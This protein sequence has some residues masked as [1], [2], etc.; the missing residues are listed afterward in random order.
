MIKKNGHNVKNNKFDTQIHTVY[1]G[2]QTTLSQEELQEIWAKRAYALAETPT[3]EATGQTLDLL[4]FLLNNE[5][6]GLEVIHVREIYPLQQITVVPRTP[7]FVVGVFSARGRLISIVDLRAF[8]GLSTL[9]LSD[10]SKVIVV[11]IGDVEVGFLTDN[12]VEVLSIFKD[13]LEP[14]L[15][16]QL[17]SHA[18]F[19]QGIAPG[20]LVVLDLKTLLQDKRLIIQEE[21]I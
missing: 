6:Y 7:D 20:M 5:H 4:V 21:I 11:A 16:S 9:T 17:G 14:P 12:V 19:A 10:D 1:N 15:A 8:F 3:V 2:T 18:D 13:D